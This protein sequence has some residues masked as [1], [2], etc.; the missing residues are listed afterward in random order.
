MSTCDVGGGDHGSPTVNAAGE[1]VGVLF[2]GNLESLP[3][4]FLYNDEQARAVHV[5]VQ[6]IAE[7]LRKV[8]KT[9]ALLDELGLGARP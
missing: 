5:A 8:Y 7:A 4:S 2:D 9:T 3:G 1:L 6:G